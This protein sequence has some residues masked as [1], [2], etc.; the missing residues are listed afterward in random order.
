M[1]QFTSFILFLFFLTCRTNKLTAQSPCDSTPANCTWNLVNPIFNTIYSIDKTNG[2][3]IVYVQ[4]G[5]QYHDVA[6]AGEEKCKKADYCSDSDPNYN[7]QDTFKIYIYYPKHDYS[8]ATGCKLP[9]FV[10]IHGGGTSDCNGIDNAGSDPESQG[11]LTVCQEMAKRGFVTFRIE[12]RRGRELDIL[13]TAYTSVQQ[14]SALYRGAQDIRGALR[15]IIYRQLYHNSQFSSDPYQIDYTKIFLGGNSAGAVLALAATYFQ[16][17]TGQFLINQVFPVVGAT[18][19]S[20]VMGP[21]NNTIYK[22][23]T[24]INYMQGVLGVCNMWGSLVVTPDAFNNPSQ[25]LPYL[26]YTPPVISFAGKKDPVF[27]Y[28]SMPVY[29]S[30]GIGHEHYNSTSFCIPNPPYTLDQNP[31]LSAPDLYALGSKGIYDNILSPLSVPSELYLDCTMKHGIT[32]N[33]DAYGYFGTLLTNVNDVYTYIVQRTAVFFQGAMTNT[34][35]NRTKVVFE[36]C[37]NNRNSCLSDSYG[38]SYTCPTE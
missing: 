16:N 7:Y 12:Y 38:T 26:E 15:Y 23:P 18:N 20:S 17:S 3:P 37:Q 19:I 33:T 5:V 9:A 14:E 36:E 1:K 10:Y 35:G 22:A 6:L 24:S 25:Y 2:T 29:F 4:S 21:V 34:L 30:A 31:S 28:I 11:A 8:D 32:G 27:N 13:N